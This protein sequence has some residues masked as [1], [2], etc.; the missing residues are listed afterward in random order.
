MSILEARERRGRKLQMLAF[1]SPTWITIKANAISSI[2]LHPLMSSVVVIAYDELASKLPLH[3]QE[4]TLDEEGLVFYVA[5]DI[6]GIEAKKLCVSLE[7]THPIGRLFDMDVYELGRSISRTE[8]NL[9]F[10]QCFICGKMVAQCVRSKAH[11]ISLIEAYSLKKARE[12]LRETQGRSALFGM[13]AELTRIRT[14]G[15]VGVMH[16]GVHEDMD[17]FT[18]VASL[19]VLLRQFDLVDNHMIVNFTLLREFGKRIET[20]MFEATQGKNTHKGAVFLFLFAIAADMAKNTIEQKIRFIQSLAHE[21]RNDFDQTPQTYGLFASK[22]YSIVSI[23]HLVLEGLSLVYRTFVPLVGSQEDELMASI[24]SQID[25]T[26]TLKRSDL[27][28]LR[29]LQAWAHNLLQKRDFKSM[30]ELDEYYIKH[31]LSSGGCADIYALCY[32]IALREGNV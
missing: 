2:R 4:A 26:T 23:R 25:D 13:V 8:L 18:Y 7:E 15:C 20:Q 32:Y 12:Y 17:F 16:S 19:R 3:H 31:R 24:L 5:T 21:V 27:A 6:S 28:T 11:D 29:F 14:Y 9:A 30:K 10:R 1:S 22:S